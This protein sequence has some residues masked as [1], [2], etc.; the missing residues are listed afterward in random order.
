MLCNATLT[1]NRSITLITLA[2]AS[3]ARTMPG[4]PC[5]CS[6]GTEVLS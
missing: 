4:C 5:S 3:V 6:A 1:M 2:K